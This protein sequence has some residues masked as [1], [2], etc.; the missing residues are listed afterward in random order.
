MPKRKFWTVG[1]IDATGVRGPHEKELEDISKAKNSLFINLDMDFLKDI[2]NNE[3]G[4]KIENLGFNEDWTISIEMFPEV[5]IHMAY[6]YFGDEFGDG[7]EAEF[8]FFFSGKRVCW[9]PGEDN[10]TFIDIVLDFIE[11]KV[12]GQEPFEKNY[13]KKT[14]LMEKVLKQRSE[15]FSLLKEDDKE[16]LA[17]FLGAKV[18][19]LENGWRIKKEFFSEIFIEIIWDKEVLDIK[20]SGEK[21]SKNIDNY[22][23]EFVGIFML[24][25]ILRFITVS[26]MDKDLPD[27]CYI[28]FS[29][30]YTKNI[31]N[32]DHRI[33]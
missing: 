15:P 24:N 5:D 8:K 6:S 4:G 19:K 14:D 11:R 26:N 21:M 31:G 22:H 33:R 25:H 7:I 10:A 18:W 32:W 2:V 9:V 12:K 23:V 27:I 16:E 20:F 1:Q 30:Y 13:N 17:S 28:M 3:L 29:R